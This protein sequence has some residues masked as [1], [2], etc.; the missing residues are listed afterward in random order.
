MMKKNYRT[1]SLLAI[2]A[3]IMMCSLASAADK[4]VV[5]PI[6]GSVGNATTADVLKDK[7]FSSRTAG[8]GATGTLELSQQYA[9]G[10]TGPAGGKVFWVSSNGQH[11]LEAAPADQG[12]DVWYNGTF[13]LIDA[14]RDGVNAGRFNTERIIAKQGPS[15]FAI[16]AAQLCSNYKGGG[17]GDWYLPSS[18][19]LDMMYYNLHVVGMGGFA[20]SYYWSSTEHNSNGAWGQYFG[21]GMRNAY[22]KFLTYFRVRAVRAF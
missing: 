5:L 8:R 6:G 14:T 11:G 4:V 22:D 9:I 17:Y 7:T 10:D 20:D 16:Y 2:S 18:N 13:I 19:E 3:L 21:S 1:F 12:D 15:M